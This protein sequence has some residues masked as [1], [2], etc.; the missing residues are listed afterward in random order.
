[1]EEG[2]VIGRIY[3]NRHTL[4]ALRWFW[5][6]TE[7]VDPVLEITTHGRLPTFEQAKAEFREA[8]SKWR[9]SSKKEQQ[10]P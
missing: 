2:Q 6:I 10:R 8:W 5:S 7:Y 9:A 3:E 4:P 1:M